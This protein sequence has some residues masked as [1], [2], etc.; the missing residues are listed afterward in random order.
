MKILMVCLGNICRSP[1]AEGI[2]QQKA[3]LAKLDWQVDSAGTYGGHTG[4]YPDKRSQYVALKNDID[5]SQ[6]KARQFS[7]Y[8]FEIY[9]H[10]FVMDAMNY[11]DVVRLAQNDD[12]RNK[13]KFIL[14]EVFPMENR[15]VP[16]PYYGEFGFEN[17]YQL[18]D[19][20]CTKIIEKYA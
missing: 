20:A 1:L 14:N 12:E 11:K 2:L 9:D 16:D 19:K 6:Q 13:V 15:P 18:L 17:V 3:K 7:T 8:D 5:I 10:I 4:E